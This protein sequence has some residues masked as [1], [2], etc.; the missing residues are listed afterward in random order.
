VSTLEEAL[1]LQ[2]QNDAGVSALVSTRIYPLVV[3]QDATLPAIAY[4]RISGPRAY[5]HS[6]PTGAVQARMQITSVASDYSGAKALSAAVRSAMRSFRG[7]GGL[8]VDAVFEENESDTWMDRFNMPVVRQD[9]LIH[10]RE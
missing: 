8:D 5:S 7:T 4:Q 3:P 2:L 10:Y 9:F 1:V 6:G